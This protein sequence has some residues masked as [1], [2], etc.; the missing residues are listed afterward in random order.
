MGDVCIEMA[1]L[2]TTFQWE[3]I[4]TA[5]SSGPAQ[6]F[7]RN[8][9]ITMWR[10]NVFSWLKFWWKLDCTAERLSWASWCDG[11][12]CFG[13]SCWRWQCDSSPDFHLFR[14]RSTKEVAGTRGVLFYELLHE[15]P[16]STFLLKSSCWI[17][18]P[19]V[20]QELWVTK[21]CS[22]K[23]RIFFSFRLFPSLSP[24]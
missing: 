8:A 4:S 24:I 7:Q 14:R 13:N 2:S 21:G 23:F 6:L 22:Q 16:L 20:R 19:S 9:V 3:R 10:R 12:L 5:L 17:K 11:E 18:L 1:C 15:L